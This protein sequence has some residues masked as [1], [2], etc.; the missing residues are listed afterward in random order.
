MPIWK[1]V[2]VVEEPDISLRDWRIMETERE[3]RHFVG[4]R[5]DDGIGRV[6][7]AIVSFDAIRMT[8]IT[9]SG[10]VYRLVGPP[11]WTGD[12]DY[13]WS[14]WRQI[15]RVSSYADVTD[16]ALRGFSATAQVPASDASKP[17]DS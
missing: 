14:A 13:V 15:N 16:G 3:E 2:P 17:V 5:V 6:S 12:A 10:R 9:S 7:S 4:A 8:G 11:G 1:G